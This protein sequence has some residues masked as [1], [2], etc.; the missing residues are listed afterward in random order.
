MDEAYEKVVAAQ[1]AAG[2]FITDVLFDPWGLFGILANAEAVDLI[3]DAGYPA[4]PCGA[5]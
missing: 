4:V 1:E 5:D 3:A 2:G